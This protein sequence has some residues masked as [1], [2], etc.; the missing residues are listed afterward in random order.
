MNCSLHVASADFSKNFI[1]ISQSPGYRLHIASLVQPTLQKDFSFGI[2]NDKEKQE[3]VTSKKVNPA[4]IKIFS[5]KM[6]ED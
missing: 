5:W 2:I 6:I 4:N 1:T 3:I